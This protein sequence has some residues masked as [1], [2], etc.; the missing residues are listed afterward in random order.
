MRNANLWR[1]FVII[2]LA[3]WLTALFLSVSGAVEKPRNGG[4]LKIGFGGQALVS[5]G[6]PPTMSGAQDGQHSEGCLESLFRYDENM[7][8]VSRL[9]TGWSVGPNS[10]MITLT[11][12][13]GVKFHDGSDFNAEVVKWNLDQF[14]ASP[15]RHL[16]AVTSVDVIDDYTIRLNLSDYDCLIINTLASDAGR[17]ISKKAF[18]AHGK[19]WCEK[20]PVGTGPFKF[21]SWEKDVAI[22]LT[23]FDQYWQPGR[24]Y[25]D[26]YEKHYFANSTAAMMVFKN[27][28]V[29]MLFTGSQIARE[30]EAEGKYKI[31][32]YRIGFQ[33]GL[34]G[35][36]LHPESPFADLRVRQAMRYALDLP[37]LCEALGF[38]YWQPLTQ[39]AAP[40]LPSYNPDVK[41]YPYNP[42]KAKKLLAEAGYGKGFD[43]TLSYLAMGPDA[44]EWYT[45]V[46]AYLKEVG[47]RA[48]LNPLQRSAYHQLATGG[49]WKGIANVL[50]MPKPEVLEPMQEILVPG[51][52]KFPSIKYPKGFR[53]LF[54]KAQKAKDM[55]SRI[56][57]TRE[58]MKIEA[59]N[60][61]ITWLW[62]HA[63]VTV[64]W[65]RVHDDMFC[66]IPNHYISP[67]AWLSE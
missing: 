35:D 34:A 31:A 8:L 67:D 58:L 57:L 39:W 42:E 17:M 22:K 53:E 49:G 10:K 1:Y 28:E 40:Q 5:I 50:V 46:Q 21:V 54:L 60:C 48:K 32:K 6:Y 7:N 37:T 65:P 44:T 56:T 63:N 51:S 15:K 52:I 19:E 59:E 27:G 14:R 61:P 47:I 16:N 4:I 23:R 11:L 36:S 12:R 38:G 24:P 2:G 30:L 62:N 66:V 13:K 3:L 64:K 43:T 45:A 18:E 25:L 20:N 33:H 26:G 41:R 29:D 9:A 55:D